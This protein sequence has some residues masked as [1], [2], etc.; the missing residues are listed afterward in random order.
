[1]FVGVCRE[2]ETLK[3][4]SA[5]YFLFFLLYQPD[6]SSLKHW[7]PVRRLRPTRPGP[8]WNC[9]PL[10]QI[11]RS[12][13]Q[14]KPELVFISRKTG[15]CGIWGIQSFNNNHIFFNSSGTSSKLEFALSSAF[16]SF[17]R[18]RLLRFNTKTK[19][20]IV[21]TKDILIYRWPSSFQLSAAADVSAIG[22][23][24]ET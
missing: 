17:F 4:V 10:E 11:W 14:P 21:S 1:V 8:G 2:G 3:K 24:K 13:G 15:I 19:W 12:R 23:T 20:I 18:E 22:F 16:I 7:P 6:L 5:A 9:H